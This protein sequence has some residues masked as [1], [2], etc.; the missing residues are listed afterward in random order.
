MS[1]KLQG[2][3]LRIFL[4]KKKNTSYYQANLS[5]KKADTTVHWES[6]PQ[7]KSLRCHLCTT[8]KISQILFD[9]QGMQ[10]G[11]WRA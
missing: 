4:F 1:G 2:M 5:F 6:R 3:F 10:N 8:P 9:S 7:T 11:L